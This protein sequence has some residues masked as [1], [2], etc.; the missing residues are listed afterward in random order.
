M[1]SVSMKCF[2]V[3]I[4]LL[5]VALLFTH[6]S[7]SNLHFWSNNFVYAQYPDISGIKCDQVEHFNFHYHAHLN[8]FIN[9]VSYLVPGGIGIKPP[10]CIYWLHTHDDSGIIH[11]ESPENKS[12]TLGQFFDVWDKKFNNSQIFDFTANKSEN[13]TLVVYINGT[14]VNEAQYREVPIVNHEDITIVY[15]VPPADIPSYDFSY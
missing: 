15:G 9:G 14:A 5:L 8:I 4:L 6:L 2:Q 11:V 3:S 7:F 10:E 12:F 13:K 1:S